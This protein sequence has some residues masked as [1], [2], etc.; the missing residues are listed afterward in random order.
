MTDVAIPRLAETN[1]WIPIKLMGKIEE[2]KP[3]TFLKPLGWY[4]I[5]R[6]FCLSML[7]IFFDSRRD[8][9]FYDL[10]GQLWIVHQKKYIHAYL[11][12]EDF[13]SSFLSL[14]FS[15]NIEI[16]LFLWI[17]SSFSLFWTCD[18]F[19]FKVVFLWRVKSDS[20]AT[21]HPAKHIYIFLF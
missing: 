21:N 13:W 12:K 2:Q 14:L 3:R 16:Y 18:S 19:S 1:Y 6:I 7:L 8:K 4:P 9:R 5:Y 10:A 11:A 20:W 15:W 17:C